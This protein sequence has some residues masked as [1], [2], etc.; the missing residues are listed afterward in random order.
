[1]RLSTWSKLGLLCFALFLGTAG[2]DETCSWK[3]DGTKV[4]EDDESEHNVWTET[5]DWDWEDEEVELKKEKP[6]TKDDDD[7]ETRNPVTSQ[8][9]NE[10]ELELFVQFFNYLR[11]WS[12]TGDALEKHSPERIVA[13]VMDTLAVFDTNDDGL[14]EY[15]EVEAVVSKKEQHEDLDRVKENLDEFEGGKMSLFQ[16]LDSFKKLGDGEYVTSLINPFSR[17]VYLPVATA[18]KIM[19]GSIQMFLDSDIDLDGK[20]DIEEFQAGMKRSQAK[21][22]TEKMPLPDEQLQAIFGSMDQDQDETLTYIE[23]QGAIPEKPMTI[24][25]SL[26]DLFQYTDSNKDGLLSEDEFLALMKA[27]A[28]KMQV[29]IPDDEEILDGFH[30]LDLNEDGKLNPEEMKGVF[31]NLKSAQEKRITE[32]FN[33]FDS[34][35]DGVLSLEELAII[36]QGIDQTSGQKLDLNILMT[37]LD[38][39]KDGK[40]SLEEMREVLSQLMNMKMK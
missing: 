23:F 13:A 34:D 22:G 17:L 9:F 36:P 30:K 39:N 37:M 4:C 29:D 25:E 5:K 21:H 20:L 3:A 33:S 27:R 14:L 26:R 18:K 16:F 32:A 6:V 15:D 35:G 38:K 19:Q 12:P 8:D 11:D 7:D 28:T 31:D 40:V 10:L 1:M 2:A 24:D